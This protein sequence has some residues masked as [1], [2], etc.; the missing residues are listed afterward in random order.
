VRLKAQVA[1]LADAWLEL[2]KK[3]AKEARLKRIQD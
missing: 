1:E 3:S 2:K